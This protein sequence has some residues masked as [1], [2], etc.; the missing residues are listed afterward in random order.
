MGNE[1]RDCSG[2]GIEDLW[3]NE[4]FTRLKANIFMQ[5]APAALFEAGIN[6]N[7]AEDMLDSCRWGVERA[8]AGCS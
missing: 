1:P 3:N 8:F 7:Y 5:M 4:I 6:Y 2:E